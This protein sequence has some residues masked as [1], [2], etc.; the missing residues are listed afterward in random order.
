[1]RPAQRRGIPVAPE[2]S[3]ACALPESHAAQTMTDHSPERASPQA[4]PPARYDFGA[5]EPRW[6]SEWDRRA[7]F[8]VPD[9]PPPGARKY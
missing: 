7:C 9:V 1:M 8:A 4:T 3:Y 5:A 6:Q 2:V